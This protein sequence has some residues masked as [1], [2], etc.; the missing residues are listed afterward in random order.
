MSSYNSRVHEATGY[1][2]YEAVHGGPMNSPFEIDKLP[3]GIRFKDVKGLARRLK[4][5]WKKVRGNNAKAMV[6]QL[7]RNNQRAKMPQYKVG[8]FVMLRN[9]VVR[10][11][12]VKKFSPLYE[13]PY[14][15]MQLTSPVNAEIQLADRTVTIHFDRLKLYKGWEPHPL[16]SKANPAT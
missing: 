9:P 14:P 10:K 15:I 16:A 13:G 6:Q 2:P 12:M 11:G 3:K 1:S 4:A 7:K 8:G 5:I